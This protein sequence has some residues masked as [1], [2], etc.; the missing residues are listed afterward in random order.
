MLR[1]RIQI[2]SFWPV[3]LANDA[4]ASDLRFGR[5]AEGP[6]ISERLDPKRILEPS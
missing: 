1:H 3:S 2:A 4:V 6:G 5:A